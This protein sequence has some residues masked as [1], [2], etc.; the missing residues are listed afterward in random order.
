MGVTPPT[1]DR[2]VA[3]GCPVAKEGGRGRG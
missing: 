1:V 3:Q 2:W